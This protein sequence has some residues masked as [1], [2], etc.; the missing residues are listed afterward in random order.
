MAGSYNHVVTS[1]G[2]LSSNKM[3]VDMLEN[4]GDVYEAVEEMYGMIWYLAWQASA[5]HVTFEFFESL[6][7]AREI[8]K[9]I[10]ESA[11]QN[12][13]DGLEISKEI[14]RLSPDRRRT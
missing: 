9:D 13:K 14:H 8:V 1:T 2:N 5:P 10:V 12:Y 11:R 4:G 7:Y 6:E 3:V